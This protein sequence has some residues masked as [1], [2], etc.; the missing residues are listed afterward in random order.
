MLDLS[1]NRLESLPAEIG[2]LT[3]LQRLDLSNNK[4][5]SL[6]TSVRNLAGSMGLLDLRDN[7]GLESTAWE[8]TRWAGDH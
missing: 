6:P 8:E 3:S 4:L 5:E 7:P 2:N 1:D